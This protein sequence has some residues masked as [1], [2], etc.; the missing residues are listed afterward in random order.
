MEYPHKIG[1]VSILSNVPIATLRV[2]EARYEAFAPQK[3]ASRHRLYS[4]VD[5][6]RAT[7][8]KQ[9][10]EAGHAI[11]SIAQL[12]A[13]K[14]SHLLHEYRSSHP[15][16]V[17][18]GITAKA[19][20]FQ[21][22]VVGLSLAARLQAASFSAKLGAQT[23]AVTDIFEDLTQLNVNAFQTRPQILLLRSNSVLASDHNLLQKTAA[24][25]RIRHIIVLYSYAQEHVIA[26]MRVSGMMVRREPI[27]DDELADLLRSILMVAP[28]SS[29]TGSQPSAVIPARQYSDAVLNK[30]AAISSDVLCECPRHV[31]ELIMQLANFEQYSQ[32]CLNKSSDDAQ[33]HA[34]LCAASGSARA[35]FERALERVAQ[36]EGIDLSDV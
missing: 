17:Q 19:Q 26:A 36:H 18:Q 14:L 12:D 21:V 29:M 13:N 15:S 16:P 23:L 31:A 8:M 35:L 22:A 3:T 33:L 4:E 27:S 34:Y 2:W 9:L 24:A 10:T 6:L 28:S 30:M 20:S 32:D 1:Q 5:A 7:L 11:S 25:L